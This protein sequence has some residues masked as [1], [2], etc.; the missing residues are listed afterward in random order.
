MAE[1]PKTGH[2]APE[3][4]GV[5]RSGCAQILPSSNQVPC[6]SA[7]G[8]GNRNQPVLIQN[9]GMVL[10]R[11]RRALHMPLTNSLTLKS[12]NSIN[13]CKLVEVDQDGG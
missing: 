9:Q 10:E 4:P 3:K 1:G 5:L 2:Q 13:R 12:I 11:S 7:S 8:K 6:A